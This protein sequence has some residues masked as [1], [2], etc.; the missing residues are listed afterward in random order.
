MNKHAYTYTILQYRHDVWSGECMNV[1][2]LV[3]CPD[4]SYLK[5]RIRS[6]GARLSNAYPGI[7]RSA[8]LHDMRELERWFDRKNNE[9]GSEWIWRS[10]HDI[11]L[12]LLGN[13]D[14]S[15]R[16]HLDA[17]GVTNNPEAIHEQ[18]FQRLV[19]KHDPE[20][21]RMPR[22]DEQVFEVVKSKL[23]TAEVLS[24]MEPHTVRS[25][26]S[27]VTFEHSFKNGKWHCLQA[28]SLDSADAEQMQRKAERWA[29]VLVGISEAPEPFTV[30]LVTGKPSQ[31]ELL[32]QYE[33]MM[34]LLRHAPTR[35]VVLDEDESDEVARRIAGAA[36]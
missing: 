18:L 3:Y 4:L 28:I 13:D 12:H 17:S 36:H 20:P 8:L 5:L 19:V 10:A 6:G 23:K 32:R 16:W 1:G 15:L 33:R 9:R 21:G 2:V 34:E 27:E 24:R 35:P 31:S 22:S 11:G 25:S 26:Y 14:S 30:Y 29:G 7:D